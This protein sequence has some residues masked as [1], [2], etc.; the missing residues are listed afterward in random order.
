V[1]YSFSVGGKDGV[2]YPVDKKVMDETTE[3]LI[4]GIQEA[5]LGSRERINAL[6]RLRKFV[7]EDVVI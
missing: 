7:P 2:P 5:K 1:K 3:I 4:Q 6:Q